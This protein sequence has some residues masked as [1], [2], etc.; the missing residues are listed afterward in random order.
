[1]RNK[2]AL[3]VPTSRA[4]LS[5]IFLLFLCLQG[6]GFNCNE[7]F[8]GAEE[9]LKKD[10]VQK[11][12]YL[13][14]YAGR[15]YLEEGNREKWFECIWEV[16]D[17]LRKSPKFG[18]GDAAK[19][20]DSVL[21]IKW[22]KQSKNQEDSWIWSLLQNGNNHKKQGDFQAALEYYEKAQ[23]TISRGCNGLPWVRCFNVPVVWQY[24]IAPTQQ[25]YQA[26]GDH[27]TNIN[28]LS[29]ELRDSLV[30]Q[31][32]TENG[33]LLAYFYLQRGNSYFNLGS[34]KEREKAKK[35][36]KKALRV[37]NL[38]STMRGIVLMILG[39]IQRDDEL[40]DNAY[41][42]IQIQRM[43]EHHLAKVVLYK[44]YL[45]R[46][47]KNIKEAIDLSHQS[48][49]Y[50]QRKFSYR[51]NLDYGNVYLLLG[52]LYE[53]GGEFEKAIGFY[54]RC[55]RVYCP[56]YKL[57]DS[58]ELPPSNALVADRDLIDALQGKAR[59]WSKKGQKTQNPLL[60]AKGLQAFKLALLTEDKLINLSLGQPSRR[61]S[62]ARRDTITSQ[63]LSI[64]HRQWLL[65]PDDSLLDLAF[66]FMEKSRSQELQSTLAQQN[67][68][69]ELPPRTKKLIDSLKIARYSVAHW[70]RQLDSLTNLNTP[71]KNRID[72][73][74]KKISRKKEQIFTLEISLRQSSPTY[75][76]KAY[77]TQLTNRKEFAEQLSPANM[78]LSYFENDTAIYVLGINR[79]QS[80]FFHVPKDPTFQNDLKFYEYFLKK[81]DPLEEERITFQSV[82]HRIYKGLVE[83]IL[84]I[85]GIE[86]L[87]IST[88]TSS[89]NALP[90]EALLTVRGNREEAVGYRKLKFLWQNY[91]ISYAYSANLYATSAQA[92][93]EYPYA[94]VGF[95]PNYGSGSSNAE[96]RSIVDKDYD[97]IYNIREVQNTDTLFA[98]TTDFH[99]ALLL[100]EAIRSQFDKLADS[101]QILHLA[102]HAFS[103]DSLENAH[104]LLFSPIIDSTQTLTSTG[105]LYE[106]D[107]YSRSLN[108]KLVI[109]SACNSGTG[110]VISGEGV[111]HLG[112]AFRIAGASNVLTSLWELNDYAPSQI[113][114]QFV[115]YLTEGHSKV[116]ALKMARQDF[117]Y[118][119]G[120]DY[121]QV[122]PYYWANLVLEG[123]MHPIFTSHKTDG[124]N[125]GKR[126]MGILLGILLLG[127][128]GWMVQRKRFI[129]RKA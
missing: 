85:E 21:V 58:L 115:K 56:S 91:L 70:E 59:I 97:L 110:E 87:V 94:Y 1:M 66:F 116:L 31:Y 10:S 63:A 3:D 57:N 45:A 8:I 84:D 80:L 29:N 18:Y 4:N 28:L 39:R 104:Y 43:N 123:D 105:H 50:L 71:Y 73:L 81:P 46:D 19:F 127:L 48:L 120:K 53:R 106:Y 95:A 69:R 126:Y 98:T 101:A 78:Y 86:E 103:L 42:L 121:E 76:Q 77:L 64:L 60:L 107:I 65:Q 118:D 41:R 114:P 117:F 62:L 90:F 35:S 37:P 99:K 125:E 88:G 92:E 67:M 75:F 68:Y 83:P 15:C 38:T 72:T 7:F 112:R 16:N 20:L 24:A 128:A 55:I 23:M 49:T 12:K 79:A 129:S 5:S 100:D 111:S 102:M 109:L 108:N 40:L 25:I 36:F 89:L 44:A 61:R 14:I 13:F 6:F 22:E 9:A 2:N 96:I 93:R 54:H 47:E 17:I 11:A 122:A 26:I 30:S 52:E 27:E 32:D 124:R 33:D 119:G 113:V 74:Q 34:N 82:A 51:Y